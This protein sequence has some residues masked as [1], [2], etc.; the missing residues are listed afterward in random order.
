ML[1]QVYGDCRMYI[2]RIKYEYK[3]IVEPFVVI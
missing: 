1:M 2:Y 3:T